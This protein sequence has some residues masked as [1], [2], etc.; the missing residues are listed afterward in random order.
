MCQILKINAL[1][2]QV[3]RLGSETSETSFATEIPGYKNSHEKWFQFFLFL[4][5]GRKAGFRRTIQALKNFMSLFQ[6]PI[7]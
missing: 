2:Y 7:L 4:Y 6:T 3:S 5:G 1:N